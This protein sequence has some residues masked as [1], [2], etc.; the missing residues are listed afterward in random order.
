MLFDVFVCM[1]A[2]R[3]S[4]DR[5]GMVVCCLTCV[6]VYIYITIRRTFLV[7]YEIPRI[8]L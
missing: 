6:C 8:G 7:I 2:N 3:L 4:T 5:N 1:H